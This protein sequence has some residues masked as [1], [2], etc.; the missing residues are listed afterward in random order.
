M[1]RDSGWNWRSMISFTLLFSMVI[2]FLSGVFLYVSPGGRIA[3]ETGWQI[4]GFDKEGWKS[5]HDLFGF[6]FILVTLLHLW[7]NRRAI[8]CYMRDR[9]RNVYRL[10]AELIAAG[11]ITGIVFLL[12]ALRLLPL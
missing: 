5:I 1:P 8:A 4:L 6:F 7:L 3:R 12:A 10:R 9:V 2:L 11:A